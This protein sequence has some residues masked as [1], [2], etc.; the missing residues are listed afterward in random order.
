MLIKPPPHQFLKRGPDFIRDLLRDL[1]PL[2]RIKADPLQV[3]NHGIDNALH[4]DLVIGIVLK[5]YLRRGDEQ[6]R[7][8]AS[9]RLR[10]GGLCA[11]ASQ[12]LV[13]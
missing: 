2:G 11:V 5:G 7:L 3:A 8:S 13:W 9:R 10:P 12:Q 4:R 1:K 6:F